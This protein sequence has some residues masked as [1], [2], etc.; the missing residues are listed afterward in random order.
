MKLAKDLGFTSLGG[1]W[2]PLSSLHVEY[3]YSGVTREWVDNPRFY[4][5]EEVF[6]MEVVREQQTREPRV[7]PILTA[8]QQQPRITAW[9]NYAIANGSTQFTRR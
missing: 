8:E 7:I 9:Q 4:T 5:W 2:Y 3:Y 6:R 1:G